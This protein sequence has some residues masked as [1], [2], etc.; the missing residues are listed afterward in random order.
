M[1]DMENA[2]WGADR[3][4]SNEAPI[5]HTFVTAMIKGDVSVRNASAGPYQTGV[6]FGGHDMAPCNASGCVLAATDT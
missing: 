4:V 6:D 3:I 5:N 1:A 2:L